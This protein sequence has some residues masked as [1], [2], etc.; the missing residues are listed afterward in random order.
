MTSVSHPVSA[1]KLLIFF[2]PQKGIK[3]KKW[4]AWHDDGRYTIVKA[5]NDRDAFD[6]A[7]ESFHEIDINKV[8]IEE[9]D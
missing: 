2:S 1:N 3:M 9:V 6:E 4:H 5:K 8:A 7:M